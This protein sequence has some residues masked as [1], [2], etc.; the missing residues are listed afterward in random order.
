MVK[1]F[2]CFCLLSITPIFLF[3]LM[4]AA[5]QPSVPPT[6]T[7][8]PRVTASPSPNSKAKKHRLYTLDKIWTANGVGGDKLNDPEA[9]SV[10][11]D[12]TV[13]IA[14]TG[15]N[16]IVV[17]DEDGKPL[18]TIGSFGTEANWRDAPQ[19]DGPCGV[20]I[21][22]SGLIYVA[23]TMNQR[24]V[25]LD[26]D[27]MVNTS[28]GTQGTDDGEFNEPRSV[29]KDHFGNI[30][31]LDSGNS[32]VQIF[33]PLGEFNSVWG[34][35]GTDDYLLN[36]PLGMTVNHIDQAIIADT[37]NFRFE[38]F[39]DGAVP[40]TQQG[41]FGEGPYQFKDPTGAAQTPT[42]VIAIADGK[43]GSVDFYDADDGEYE[44]IGRWKAPVPWNGAKRGPVFRGIA[45]DRQDRIYLTDIRHNWVVRLRP[46]GPTEQPFPIQPTPTAQDVSPYGGADY[47]IR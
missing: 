21:V 32:R 23:D 22:P 40:V 8:L 26:H 38:V 45:C 7:V 16:R 29:A 46:L 4:G 13:Y 10:A 20:L 15:N 11:P 42:G 27:G 47:P 31:V 30:W 35:F 3:S 33:S 6:P 17:W 24:I 25:V 34:S 43:T 2:S 44:Y 28:W 18:R 36:N 19:F 39:N 14:D 41:W 5:P 37:G 12:D 1:Y 9:I